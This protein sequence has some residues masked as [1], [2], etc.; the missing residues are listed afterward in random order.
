[1]LALPAGDLRRQVLAGAAPR[2]HEDQRQGVPGRTQLGGGDRAAGHIRQLE[3][4]RRAAD[5]EAELGLIGREVNP[6][7]AQIAFYP[8][9][10]HAQATVLLEQLQKA[11]SPGDSDHDER[12]CDG[13]RH[14]FRGLQSSDPGN[15]AWTGTVPLGHGEAARKRSEHAVPGKRR[16]A[17]RRRVELSEAVAVRRAAAREI[18]GDRC[19]ERKQE[20]GGCQC[21]DERAP[22][23]Q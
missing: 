8:R 14:S 7:L 12:R 21:A 4:R 1:M 19:A 23:R 3:R 6:Q 17:R 9:E 13:S 20:A 2:I 15:R 10:P 22:R 5:G 11:R 16:P 18:D